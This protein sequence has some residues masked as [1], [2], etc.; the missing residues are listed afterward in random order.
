MGKDK[1]E[2]LQGTL[3]LL[4]LKTVDTLGPL[5]GWAIAKRIEQISQDLLEMKYGTLYPALMRLEQSGWISSEWGTADNN[6]RARFYSRTKQGRKQL[7]R[8]AKSWEEMAAFITRVLGST[9]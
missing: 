7:A 8:E 5:H 3:D 4:V 9:R 6:R 2:L 1:T